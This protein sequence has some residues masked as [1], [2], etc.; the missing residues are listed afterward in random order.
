MP[1]LQATSECVCVCAFEETCAV[2]FLQKQR[3]LESAGKNTSVGENEHR[4][5]VSDGGALRDR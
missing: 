3:M 4:N 1:L 5:T 2:F